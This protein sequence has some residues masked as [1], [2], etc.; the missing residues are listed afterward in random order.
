MKT[1]YFFLFSILFLNL[2]GQIRLDS[3]IQTDMNTEFLRYSINYTYNDDLLVEYNEYNNGSFNAG[4]LQYDINKNLINFSLHSSLFTFNLDYTYNQNDQIDSIKL[5]FLD[6][7]SIFEVNYNDENLVE[8]LTE[9]SLENGSYVVHG[10]KDF[11]YENGLLIANHFFDIYD[12]NEVLNKVFN[13][14]YNDENQLILFERIE[15]DQVELVDSFSYDSNGSLTEYYQYDFSSGIEEFMEKVE[16]TSNEIYKLSDIF[17][18]ENTFNKIGLIMDD[19]HSE[20]RIPLSYGNQVTESILE[21]ADGNLYE[22]KWYYSGMINSIKPVEVLPISIYPNPTTDQIHLN[23]S[24][25]FSNFSIYDSDAQLILE[26]QLQ[27][28]I[29]QVNH[30]PNGHYTLVCQDKHHQYYFSHFVKHDN[31]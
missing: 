8:S 4:T 3:I 12:E 23:T 15:D 14:Y 26:D 24:I 16:Y 29:I 25:S 30:L 20:F 5:N 19:F 9:S 17:P 6:Y 21:L 2:E 1:C 28:P 18:M 27:T 10:R 22:T 13:Y 31:Y 11:L 7:Q